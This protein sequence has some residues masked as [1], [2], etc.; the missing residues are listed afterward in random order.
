MQT[1]LLLIPLNHSITLLEIFHWLTSRYVIIASLIFS[2][3]ILLT[4]PSSLFEGLIYR[5]GKVAW[6]FYLLSF[7]VI[8]VGFFVRHYTLSMTR[9][10]FNKILAS[11][12]IDFSRRSVG[13]LYV[14]VTFSFRRFLF[15]S[16]D[17]LYMLLILSAKYENIWWGVHNWDIF[18]HLFLKVVSWFYNSER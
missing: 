18:F 10:S 7:R 3:L 12:L 17:T 15:C 13:F 8:K 4:F 1:F 9:N 2:K 5:Q 11:K 14:C 16:G 6:K